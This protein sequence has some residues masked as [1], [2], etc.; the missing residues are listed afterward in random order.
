MPNAWQRPYAAYL[1]DL[2]GTLV[3]TAPDIGVA[4]N[5][6]LATARL[7]PVSIELTR[8]WVGHGARVLIEQAIEH[9]EK[10]H[11]A[12]PGRLDVEPMLDVF[13]RYYADHLTDTSRFYPTVAATLAVL[14]GRGAK[15]AVVTNKMAALS[16]PLVRQLGAWDTFDLVVCGDTTAHPKPHPE[17]VLHTLDVIGVAANDALFVGDSDTDVK[18]AR[19]AGMTVVC[20]RDGYNHGVDVTTLGADAVIDEMAE[21]LG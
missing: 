8:H 1:F 13:L 20:M 10:I 11:G 6:A 16:E 12:Q 3:D 9:H 4:L 18:A 15:L 21:I 5:H 7:D 2:D 14:K 17:P 19:A